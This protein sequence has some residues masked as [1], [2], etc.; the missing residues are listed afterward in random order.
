ML[1]TK[2]ANV[3]EHGMDG[4]D[5]FFS[6]LEGVLRWGS[7]V[8]FLANLALRGRTSRWLLDRLATIK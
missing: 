2:A 7:G 1:E 8:S 5:W 6:R 3:A 4:P